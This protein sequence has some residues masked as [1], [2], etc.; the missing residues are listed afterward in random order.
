MTL[1]VHRSAGEQ[2]EDEQDKDKQKTGSGSVSPKFCFVQSDF[3]FSLVSIKKLLCMEL[4]PS[5]SEKMTF[6]P[7]KNLLVIPVSRQHLLEHARFF[8]IVHLWALAICRLQGVR[9]S[10]FSNLPPVPLSH[11]RFETSAPQVF[12]A[13]HLVLAGIYENTF[14]IFRGHFERLEILLVSF[15]PELGGGGSRHSSQSLS[16]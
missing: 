9:I 16:Y 5:N 12:H 7:G 6:H 3:F 8:A 2:H 13:S 1:S 15:L 4:V 14:S 11:I 10:F